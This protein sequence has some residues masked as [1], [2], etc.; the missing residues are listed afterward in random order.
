MEPLDHGTHVRDTAAR[1]RQQ[2]AETMTRVT[3]TRR[4]D[5]ER[6]ERVAAQ[7]DDRSGSAAEP[8]PG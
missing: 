8:P 1:V 3:A 5:Q 7:P 6:R 2:A 4:A